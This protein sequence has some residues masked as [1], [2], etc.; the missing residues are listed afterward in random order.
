[1]RLERRTTGRAGD[2]GERH[3]RMNSVL[4]FVPFVLVD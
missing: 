1:V 3:L 2:C 4:H